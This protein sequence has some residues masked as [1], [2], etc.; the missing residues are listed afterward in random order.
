[1]TFQRKY[2]LIYA[3]LSYKINGCAFKVHNELGGGHL[4]SVYQ[5]AMAIA[6]RNAK[7]EFVE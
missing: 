3:V 6:L 7:L 1:M 4:E 2:D 5:K